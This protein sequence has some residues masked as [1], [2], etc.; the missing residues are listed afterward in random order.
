MAAYR[1]RM[2][3]VTEAGVVARREAT[4]AATPWAA[5]AGAGAVAA[6]AALATGE[7]LSGLR[8]SIPSLVLGVADLVVAETPGGVVRWS[9]DTFGTSQK[10]VLMTGIVVVTL[11][12][13]GLFGV[14]ARRRL[15][16]GAAGFAAFGAVG[17][18]AGARRPLASTTWSWGAALVATAVGIAVLWFLLGRARSSATTRDEGGRPGLDRRRFLL[19][20]GAAALVAVSGAAVGRFLR[21]AGNVEA[22]RNRLA[23]L[24][25]ART[26]EPTVPAGVTTLETTVDGIAPIVTSN[27]DFYRIDTAILVPQ[28]DPAD[29]TLRI[30]GMVDREIE[31]TFGELVDMEQLEEFIT[32]SCVSNEVGGDLVGNAWWSGVPLGDL[33]DRAGARAGATQVVGR[34][35][36]GWTAG[37]PIE[38]VSDGRPSMVALAMNGEPLPVEHGFPARLVVPGLYGYVS[39]TKWLTEIELTTW[40]GFDAYW[41]PRGW[42]KE[43]PIKTQSRIDVPRA[44]STVAAGATAVAGVAWAPSRSIASVEV[45]VDDEPWRRARLS[46]ELSENAWVQWIYEWD[47]PP[48]THRLQVRATD[49]TGETQTA[50]PAPPAPSGAT[51]YHAIR[52]DVGE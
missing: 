28:V 52:V 39:A 9:I 45:R 24:L 14:L 22:A 43:G 16:L 51:G 42:A 10:A 29:W 17:G 31:F 2:G 7:L 40:D 41:I 12:L 33:I 21:Q 50:E 37:F 36:D 15:W 3:P 46:G 38:V 35:V 32:L 23:A 25:A 30:T 27:A 47:A 1:R 26:T 18:W 34:S 44:G 8:R 13:G 48:G 6:G 4:P 5:A 49:G 20:S 11:A 19:T